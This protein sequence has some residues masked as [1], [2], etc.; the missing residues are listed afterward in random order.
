M[1]T[2][3]IKCSF[4]N[5][6]GHTLDARLDI[7]KDFNDKDIKAFIIFCHCFTCSKETITTFRLSRLLAESGYA[8][9]RFDFTGLGNSEGDFSATTFSST[10]DDLHSAIDYLKNNY[11]NPAFVMGHSLGGTTAL[12]V[13]QDYDFIKGIVTVA[14]PSEPE[15]VL[16]HFGH[17]LTLLEQNINA[18]FEVAGQ[19]FDIEPGFVDDVRNTDMQSCLSQLEKP[20]LI[21]NIENDALVGESNAKEIQ[22]WVKGDVTSI[23]VIGSNHLLSNREAVEMV[24]VD[25]VNWIN[26]KL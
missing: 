3:S 21:F 25:I 13:A 15:H 14:S 6:R 5:S 11:Q 8:I 10:Q 17:A 1:K 9:L 12:S 4:D 22:Q 2:K 20:V 23:N 18:S 16:H 26:E 19:Y 24:T 7:P